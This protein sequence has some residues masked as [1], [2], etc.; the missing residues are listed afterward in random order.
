MTELLDV[1]RG[2]A[3]RLSPADAT[4]RNAPYVQPGGPP[5]NTA[6]NPLDEL[7][8][9]QWVG[10]NKVPFDP[11]AQN[12]DYDMRGFWRGMQQQHPKANS[13]VDPNDNRLHYPDYWKTPSH[14][15]FSGESQWATP[16]APQWTPE[17][18]LVSPGGRILFD[19]KAP[20]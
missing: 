19:D 20:H 16:V 6:L 7:Q 10:D 17:D 8:F 2:A 3:S 13:A 14:E 4:A 11:N 5:T 12:S 1:I 9:R 18:K 15:T